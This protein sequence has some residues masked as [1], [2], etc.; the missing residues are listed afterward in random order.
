MV[1]Q[2]SVLPRWCPLQVSV[3]PRALFNRSEVDAAALAFPVSVAR[4]L[5]AR[6]AADFDWRPLRHW[7]GMSALVA[8]HGALAGAIALRRHI[9]C[10]VDGAARL[11]RILHGA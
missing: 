4:G 3:P 11:G 9:D 5:R 6:R 10:V 8:R 1:D 7:R 2:A